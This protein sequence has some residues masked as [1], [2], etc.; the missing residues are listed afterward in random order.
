VPTTLAA[1]PEDAAA[2][3][4]DPDRVEE[5]LWLLLRGLGIG[6]YTGDGEQVL[7]GSE[8]GP[9][10]FWIYDFEF[11]LMVRMALE[12][13]RPFSE[14]QPQ[15][16][17]LGLGSG[18]DETLKLYKD[19]YDANSSAYLVRLFAAMDLHFEGDPEI[20]PLQEWLLQLDTFVPA[21][22]S[23]ST[24]HGPGTWM[25]FAG[26]GML[27]AWRQGGALSFRDSTRPAQTQPCG[28][29]VG[30][31]FRANWGLVNS[32]IGAADLMAAETVYYAIH[33]PLLARSV[34]A[35]LRVSE[36]HAHEGHGAPGDTITF[37]VGL[38]ID[39]RLGG[40]IP[41][42]LP[43]CGYLIN[44][45]PPLGSGELPPAQ[46]WWSL[47][48]EFK[49]HG[50]FR[51]IRSHVFDGSRPTE[52]DPSGNTSIIFDSRQEPANGQGE[53]RSLQQTVRSSFDPRPWIAAMGLKDPRLLAFL[54]GTINILPLVSVTLEWHE[55]VA[56]ELE[57]DSTFVTNTSTPWG[58]SGPINVTQH[59]HAVVPLEWSEEDQTYKGQASL[60]YV[61]FDV[62]PIFGLGGDGGYFLPCPNETTAAA[63]TFHVLRL[64]G[65]MDTAPEQPGQT[66]VSG[67]ALT[68]DPGTTIE[69]VTPICPPPI[70]ADILP[71]GFSFPLPTWSQNFASAHNRETQNGTAPYIIADW[72]VGSE[73]TV[74]V[75]TYAYTNSVAAPVLTT[76]ETTTITLV[77]K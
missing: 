32:E 66:P 52:T 3:L 56:Y 51:D 6:V 30:G 11:P 15:L 60:D 25:T 57:F 35:E 12:S 61:L 48:P 37:D 55:L 71:P 2:A 67:L 26:A 31:G 38:D 77:Q 40:I 24:G 14:L 54:P 62:P 41:I 49:S 64:D 22:G 72:V 65:L 50:S 76:T 42:G 27:A 74:A 17:D 68:I 53:E 46:V 39:Y 23:T 73:Q 44:L 16:D 8:T 19:V 9:K 59:V 63:G 36:D 75:K 10:D 34:G 45:D 28:L 5:G 43:T 1:N 21:N 69:S 47:G 58:T 4:A 13:S 33:G 18:Q 7:A 29:I 70:P 20:T